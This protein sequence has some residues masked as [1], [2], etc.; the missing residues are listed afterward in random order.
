MI[1]FLAQI[2]GV[3]LNQ[4]FDAVYSISP[5]G[6]LGVTIILFTIFVRVLILPLMINQQRSMKN[7]QKVQPEIQKIQNKYKDKKDPES[8]KQ[9]S[10]EL[11]ELYKEHKISPLGGCL[12]LLIQMPIFFALFRVLQRASTY[13]TKLHDI[14]NQLAVQIMNVQGYQ[15]TLQGIVKERANVQFNETTLGTVEGLQSILSHLTTSEWSQLTQAFKDIPQTLLQQKDNIEIFLGI[16]LVDTP[17]DLMG[18]GVIIAVILLTFIAGFTTYL[19]SKVM[20]SG[21]QQ[22]NDQAAQTQKTMNIMF[23]FLTAWMTYTL[24]AGLG[25]YWIT[26]NIFQIV[27]QL[28]INK[29]MDKAGEGE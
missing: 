23:P 22:Q 24:P 20:A 14:Y 15:S 18:Q 9:M 27:Q 5:A 29:S 21:T 13:I 6:A 10:Q 8:Q 7:M 11:G 28:A 12:P 17:N 1:D 4:I 3:V 26:S 25:I 16:S 2:L 19:S